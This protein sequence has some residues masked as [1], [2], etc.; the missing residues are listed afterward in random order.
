MCE[1]N[2]ENNRRKILLQFDNLEFLTTGPRRIFN[3]SRRGWKRRGRDNSTKCNREMNRR[4]NANP[5][6]I[7]QGVSFPDAMRAY[8][9]FALS[10]KGRRIEQRKRRV[11]W[12]CGWLL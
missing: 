6:P 5:C 12:E 11:Q 3:L 8:F 1:R 10:A 7:S 4:R 2:K 9:N